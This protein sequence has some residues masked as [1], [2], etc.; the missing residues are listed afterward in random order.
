MLNINNKLV[1]AQVY[2]ERQ[3]GFAPTKEN[4]YGTTPMSYKV[5]VRFPFGLETTLGQDTIFLPSGDF[6]QT[7]QPYRSGNKVSDDVQRDVEPKEIA[8]GPGVTITSNEETISLNADP[9]GEAI[10]FSYKKEAGK[11]Y[12]V[13]PFGGIEYLDLED[14]NLKSKMT[15]VYPLFYSSANTSRKGLLV[16]HDNYPG[17]NRH[18]RGVHEPMH[19]GLS[20][21]RQKEYLAFLEQA[22]NQIMATPAGK[23]WESNTQHSPIG[24]QYIFDMTIVNGITLFTQSGLPVTR[25]RDYQLELFNNCLHFIDSVNEQNRTHH[26]HKGIAGK[27]NMGV[28]AGKTFFTFT[29]LQHLKQSSKK[30][31]ELSAPPFCLAPDE[32]VAEVT[33]TSINRQGTTTGTSAIAISKIEQMPDRKFI[34]LY[35]VLTEQAKIDAQTVDDFIKKDLQ[36][37]MLDYCKTNHLHPIQIINFLSSKFINYNLAER[38]SIFKDSIDVKR[39]LLVV[40]G[41]KTIINKTGMMGITALKNLLEQFTAVK[42]GIEK[43]RGNILFNEANQELRPIKSPIINYNQRV[44]LPRSIAT[45]TPDGTINIATITEA[46]LRSIVMTK[47]KN[48]PRASRDALMRIA[49]LQDK[50]AA[51]ILANSGGLGNTYTT[52]QLTQQ[53]K[54]FLPLAVNQLK[55]LAC[56]AMHTPGEHYTLYLYLNELFSIIPDKI[57]LNGNLDREKISRDDFGHYLYVQ[58]LK[59]NIRL[60]DTITRSIDNKIKSLK[61]IVQTSDVEPALLQ[62]YGISETSTVFEAANQLAGIASLD[63]TGIA[64]EDNANLLLTHIPVFTPEGLASYFE[65]LAGLLGQP[66]VKF[67]EQLGIYALKEQ[68]SIVSKQNIADR[69][70]QILNAVMIADEVHKEEYKFL[71]ETSN[72]IY[73]RINHITKQYLGKQF[74]DILPHR[75]GMSGTM[76]DIA[77]KA[78]GK[79]TI[80][81]LSIQKMMQQG[82]MKQVGIETETPSR[83]KF[84]GLNIFFSPQKQDYAKLIVVDY[85]IQNSHLSIKNILTTGNCTID[86]FNV[87]KGIVFSKVADQEL[88]DYLVYYFNLL[89]QKNPVGEDRAV[90]HVLFH[91]INLKR[92]ERLNLLQNKLAGRDKLTPTEI[93]HIKLFNRTTNRP[94]TV[95]DDKIVNVNK[96]LTVAPL[97]V[98]T[99]QGHHRHAFHNNLFALYLE[100]ILSKS[101]AKKE[102]SDIIGL[103]NVLFEKGV[104][105]LEIAKVK[106]DR[107][108]ENILSLMDQVDPKSITQDDLKHF[109]KSRI[110]DEALQTQWV[111]SALTHKNNHQAFA[112][113]L[114]EQTQTINLPYLVT[115]NRD[116]FESGTVMTLIGSARERT[117]YSHEPVGIVV[118][119]PADIDRLVSIN[120]FIEKLDTAELSSLDIEHFFTDLQALTQDTFSYDEKNQAGG[121]LL[122]TPYG[123]GRFIQY[124]TK[125]NALVAQG[126]AAGN[127]AISA[128]K[129]ETSFQD[130]FTFDEQQAQEERASISFNREA[131][132]LL[133]Q[134]KADINS[135]YKAVYRRFGKELQSESTQEQ[136]NQYIS[137][138]IPLIWAMKYEP[139]TAL[140]YFTEQRDTVFERIKST[141]TLPNIASL[142]QY[143]VQFNALLATL[144]KKI[145]SVIEKGTEGSPFYNPEYKTAGIQVAGLYEQLEQAGQQFFTDQTIDNLKSFKQV[146]HN[147]VDKAQ[148]EY[149]NNHR[150][151]WGQLNDIFKTILGI[152]ALITIVPAIIVA[153]KST[154]GYR[155]TFFENPPTDLSIKLNEFTVGLQQLPD[156]WTLDK[157]A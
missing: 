4:K 41:Q 35:R 135:F 90:Q 3:N 114:V 92:Q 77:A 96:L 7:L 65:H 122:R 80:Y 63:I 101:S 95:I 67:N 93:E 70:Q 49:C 133:K 146:C 11:G 8:H 55:N 99:L 147:A 83:Q 110:K 104:H 14:Y 97:T 15:G 53:I 31:P 107:E 119:A 28:G 39:L 17:Y 106:N 40:E 154:H 42:E 139:E 48:N 76:N 47:Y 121:R 5:Q 112:R 75:I 126:Q 81:N 151:L 89:I 117:G 74:I 21:Q 115:T 127:H 57:Y 45:A 140:Q 88:N 46:E 6:V 20:A 118:D 36:N 51:I 91:G 130:I 32:A 23:R 128:L 123:Q 52:E 29:L 143:E 153:S 9:G 145:D 59:D 156:D 68:T 85:F 132:I 157:T 56:K 152:V 113:S 102:A 100:Y 120:G 22:N 138:R 124:Q 71:Y 30:T 19:D 38:V 13:I 82:L 103:Q 125:I 34:K 16:H 155:G 105:L 60:V 142:N 26:L 98:E 64:A 18:Q 69:L 144:K 50:E 1:L 78:F 86:L 116:E 141:I 137:H 43:E 54:K 149:A 10:A 134:D 150:G 12:D 136:Y 109:I 66:K 79:T 58:S 148:N 62:Q 108:V 111:N 37:E 61:T 25:L 24:S 44:D 33:A 131:F 73:Q 129:L 84:N 72:P 2:V 27:I 87:S 94:V